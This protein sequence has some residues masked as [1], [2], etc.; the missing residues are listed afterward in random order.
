[1]EPPERDGVGAAALVGANDIDGFG[2][3]EGRYR[4]WLIDDFNT[5]LAVGL[6]AVAGESL[7]TP[8]PFGNISLN[9]REYGVGFHVQT[10]Q[11]LN[12]QTDEFVEPETVTAIV[13][14]GGGRTVRNAAIV[15]GALAAFLWFSVAG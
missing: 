12:P 11:D 15:V 7:G 8:I 5:E 10:L 13:L 3:V 2:G 1:M 6:I 9:Y 14:R 4:L